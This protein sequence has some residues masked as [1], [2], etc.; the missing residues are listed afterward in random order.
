MLRWQG[1]SFRS[2]QVGF[3]IAFGKC[4][5]S[6]K[7]QICA[8]A[9]GNICRRRTNTQMCDLLLHNLTLL[10]PEHPCWKVLD[11]AVIVGGAEY[12]NLLI[13]S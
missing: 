8:L 1:C 5:L 13:I 10:Q 3:D 11:H 12:R 6:G 7:A 9:L 2:K 4:Y